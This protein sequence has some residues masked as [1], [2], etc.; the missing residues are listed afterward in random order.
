M[1]EG[2]AYV[3]SGVLLINV[4]HW[5]EQNLAARVIGYAEQEGSRLRYHDQDAING[6]LHGQI[7]TL[8]FRWNRSNSY[9]TIGTVP[10]EPG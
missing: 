10:M 2:V 8:P 7:L 9:S 6:V 4:K 5:R 1:P 3:N